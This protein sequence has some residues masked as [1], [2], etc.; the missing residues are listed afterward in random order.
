MS[1]LNLFTTVYIEILIHLLDLPANLLIFL[2]SPITIRKSPFF[3]TS[4][5][6][7]E[8]LRLS[9]LFM[10]KTFIPYLFRMLS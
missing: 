4:F 1:K 6:R 8:I 9:F 5:A 2:V 7:G 10:A 3:I